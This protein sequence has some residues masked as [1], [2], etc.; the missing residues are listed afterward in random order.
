M[1]NGPKQISQIR[2]EYSIYFSKAISFLTLLRQPHMVSVNP[3][4]LLVYRHFIHTAL[5]DSSR[6]AV[7]EG[8]NKQILGYRLS[9]EDFPC[10]VDP[11]LHSGVQ[12]QNIQKE[13][14][15]NI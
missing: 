4:Y 9:Q 11:L 8:I 3:I 12:K 1:S 10:S 7:K 5:S 6:G 13:Y 14:F 2:T 15:G